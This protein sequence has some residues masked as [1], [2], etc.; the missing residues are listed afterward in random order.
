[1]KLNRTGS[2]WDRNERNKINDNWDKL[3]G[4]VNNFQGEITDKVFAEIKDSAKLNWESPVNN[5]SD[6]P[7]VAK[8][9][10][11]RFT[12]D[13]GKVY[14]YDG[15]AW[16][17]I[18][19]I[20]A[21]P[22]NSLE[23]RFNSQ[24]SSEINKRISDVRDLRES[25]ANKDEVRKVTDK[26]NP[27]DMSE[28]T[29]SLMTGGGEINLESI[30]QD[31]SVTMPKF[32]PDLRSDLR[33]LFNA[34]VEQD[35][36][37]PIELFDASSVKQGGVTSSGVTN[38]TTRTHIEINVVPGKEY[39]VTIPNSEY[40]RL[41]SITSWNEDKFIEW[42]QNDNAFVGN[43]FVISPGVNKVIIS[44][45]RV[46]PN[47]DLSVVETISELVS[48]FELR[49][50]KRNLITKIVQGGITFGGV[51][52]DNLNRTRSDLITVSPLSICNV[53][54]KESSGISIRNIHGYK[55]GKFVDIILYDM[56]NRF[57]SLFTIPSTVNQVA[58][59]F[60][61]TNPDTPL[62]TN[63]TINANPKLEESYK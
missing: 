19:E 50:V 17:E 21:G 33:D 46:K 28:E 14:R 13:T 20:N 47:E 6:L 57:Q 59:S 25:K 8:N 35:D 27:S 52:T 26:L 23:D 5:F 2:I 45:C 12:R 49:M 56:D 11:A 30:P 3:E 22:V 42:N 53:E 63:E 44:F 16:K 32:A 24:L 48:I 55:D 1:M 40:L 61:K 36:F 15:K 31:N 51:F 37:I 38:S 62:S 9:G 7:S 54:I 41:R 29:L 34:F 39:Y 58:L 60:S 18:Q 43:R 4:N 10:D